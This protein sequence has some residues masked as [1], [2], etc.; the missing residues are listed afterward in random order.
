MD[1]RTE[2]PYAIELDGL[3]RD[4][5]RLRAVDHLSLRVPA[6]EV[7]GFLGPNGAGKTTTLK[8]LAGLL[9]PTEGRA[10]VAGETVRVGELSLDLRRKVGFL[11]EEP[12]FYRWMTGEEFLVFVGRL[13]GMDEPQAQTRAG[14]LL[15]LVD[16]ADRRGDRIKGYSRGMRQ[17]LGIAQALVGDP[18]VLLLDEPA[19]ALD[20]IGR[21]EIL[22]LIASLRQ[23]ATV[24]MSSHILE[25]VQRICTWVGIMRR[26]RL[27]VEAPL[28]RLLQS[29]AQPVFRVEVAERTED[30]TEALRREP[31]LRELTAEGGGLRVLATDPAQAQRRIPVLVAGLGVRLVEFAMISPTLEDAFIQ[32]VT[33]ETP[34]ATDPAPPVEGSMA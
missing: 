6:G 1:S 17:R 2:L 11:A 29:Y 26:G 12:A 16:L 5:D 9:S 34:A 24:I 7:Y 23:R 27:L 21:K 25:D 19:S 18:E 8:M 20:P 33:D 30:L 15:S 10:S 22:D 31:W 32:L 14:E 4:F 3:T 28:D 13:Y